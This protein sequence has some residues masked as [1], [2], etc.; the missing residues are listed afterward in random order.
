MMLLPWRISGTRLRLPRDLQVAYT[1]GRMGGVT[2]A[3]SFQLWYGS[4]H[5][6]RVGFGRLVRLGLLRSFPR[7]DPLSPAWFT[8]TPKG[9]EWTAEQAGC[10]QSE[11]RAL[12]GIRRINLPALSMRNRF[13]T[14]LVMACRQFPSVRMGSFRPEWEL[15]SLRSEFVS[16][17]PDAII[18]LVVADATGERECAWVLEADGGT[19]RSAVWKGK[20]SHYADL[21]GTGRLYGVADWR[22]LAIVPSS[23]RARSVAIAV[24]AGGAGAFSYVGVDGRLDEGRAFD[25]ALWPCLELTRLPAVAPTASLLGGFGKPI[26]EADQRSRSTVDRVSASET[27]RISP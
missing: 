25:D 3:D 6:A 27:G 22:L 20:A 4:P 11:L 15:R 16:V 17:V 18:T 2:I 12:A 26:N 23:R 9:L 8:L 24:T 14:S 19:E 13:W 7:T 1:V 5:T 10:E 21:R